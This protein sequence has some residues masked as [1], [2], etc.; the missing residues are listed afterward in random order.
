MTAER[1]PRDRAAAAQSVA[2]SA[3]YRGLL[4]GPG[5]SGGDFYARCETPHGTRVIIGDVRGKGAPA[6]PKARFLASAFLVIAAARPDLEDVSLALDHLAAADAASEWDAAAREWFATAVLLEIDRRGRSVT[7]INHG[8]PA[9]VLVDGAGYGG[10]LGAAV[11]ELVPGRPRLPLGLGDLVAVD[12]FADTVQLG[13]D[14]LL[15]PPPPA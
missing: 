11:R 7:M 5:T 1:F 3:R 8:H 9:P 12:G 13:A 6:A 10:A 2:V 15:T 4:A 14:A